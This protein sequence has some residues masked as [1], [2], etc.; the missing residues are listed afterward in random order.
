M[1][2]LI[3]LFSSFALAQRDL[4]TITGTVTDPSG[5]AVP[6]AAI[7]ITNVATGESYKLETTS[8]GDYTRPALPPGTYTVAAEA[9][10]FRRVSQENVQVTA[11]SRVGIPLTLEV[12]NLA[13]SVIVNAEAPLVQSESVQ[14]GAGL[15][16]NMVTDLPLGAQ[17]TFTYLAR[18]SPGVLPPE[19]GARDQGMGGF[20]ANGLRSEGQNNF[21]LNGV[22]NNANNIDLQA[23]TS[24]VVAPPPEAIG[25]ISIMTSG[26]NAEYGRGAGGVINVNLKS[27]TNELHGGLWEI[28][29]NTD[30]NANSWQNNRN[31]VIR[32]PGIQNQ[33]GA[34]AG[35]PIIKNKF[36]IF[37]DYQGTRRAQLGSSGYDTIPTALEK[38]GNFS[39]LLGGTIG[40]DALGNTITKYEIYDPST[41]QTL[42][43]GQIVRTPFPGNI[44][45][46]SQINPA[47]S[48]I[49]ALFPATNEPVNG[50]PINDYYYQTHGLLWQ[51]SGDLRS[52]YR[53]SAKDSLYGNLSWSDKGSYSAPV[54]TNALTAGTSPTLNNL[55]RNFQ[56]GYTRVWTSSV[57]S[58][59]RVA[60]TRLMVW[61]AG[62]DN[63]V[64]EYQAFGIGGYDPTHSTP[65]NGGLP[66]TTFS[67]YTS[68][69]GSNWGPSHEWSNTFDFVQNVAIMRSSH[70][71]KFGAEYKPIRF[72]F[73]QFQVPHGELDF[74]Q[75]DTA[76]PSTASGVG[77][78]LASNSGD[79]MAAFLLGVVNTGSITTTNE[80]SAMK[81]SYSFYAQDDWKIT[82]KLTM[83]LGMRY[84]LFSP[85]AE[86]F[87]RESNFDFNNVTLYIP[88]GPDENAPLPPNFAT[89]Y[90][91]VT[92]SRGQVGKYLIPWDKWDFGPRFGLAYKMASKTVLR[93]GYGIFYGGEENLGGNPQVGEQVPFNNMVTLNRVDL[94]LKSIGTFAANPWFPGG[95]SAG[96]PSNVFTT[97]PSQIEFRGVAP[98]WRN[99][100]V[101]KWNVALQRELPWGTALEVAYVGNL[102]RH[103]IVEYAGDLVPNIGTTNSSI[104]STTQ[105]L[106]PNIAT[107]SQLT[108]TFGF[109][110]YNSLT[111]KL[112]KRLSKNV[113]FLSSYTYGHALADTGTPLTYVGTPNLLNWAN[114]Y[115]NA[116]WD[117]RHSF[118][119]SFIYQL[120][121]GKGQA[122]G[123][124][125]GSALN[126]VLGGWAVDGIL[127]IR[128]GQPFTASSNACQGVW[129]SCRPDVVAGMDPNAAPPG[130]RSPAKWFNTAGF[131]TP[132]PLTGGDEGTSMIR[133]PGNS[134]LDA[135]LFKTFR[136]TERFTMEFRFEAFNAFNKTQFGLPD[137]ALQDSTF[138][139]ITTSS[140]Q[141]NTQFA[142]RLHF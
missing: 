17:R 67:R 136:L 97:L 30:L 68:V 128:T 137:G 117:I 113:Q 57:I 55:T 49:L 141:R 82:P 51:D 142:L 134:T 131:T 120:P 91:N 104:T 43:N 23:G 69:G 86:Q 89:S 59:T 58:E 92:V 60:F 132:A 140:G 14:L 65:D 54:F 16:S 85:E 22:D 126:Q 2:S 15:N 37:A 7:T 90:P 40:T 38:Q 77:G 73:R 100:M 29:Q 4:G 66:N 33:F 118:T 115:S 122:M 109:G 110:N 83:N 79:A 81:Q 5:A 71:F 42:A 41:T 46:A 105:A 63:T 121:F 8:V 47:A 21:L 96:I 62:P 123:A 11:G 9:T 31:G 88:S 116:L 27:G 135:A 36:F 1:V 20:S 87:N 93:L 99:P 35:G 111:A 114:A 25:E 39:G 3:L 64:D 70:S 78:T 139:Q 76:Y 129:A 107:N 61:G 133:G 95:L 53:L 108:S 24:F 94:N 130:G 106:I 12:G 138:G 19:N 45:P 10:G 32:P 125:W 72:P 50:F 112:E 34:A 44:I 56:L 80:I 84:E 102:Q 103:Q 127:S 6:G 119:T 18:L 52:D 124:H 48:K 13:E 101:Q 74:S 75:N 28:L 26:Y 98:D